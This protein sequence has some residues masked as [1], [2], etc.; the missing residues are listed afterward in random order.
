VRVSASLQAD[1]AR[2]ATSTAAWRK[3]NMLLSFDLHEGEPAGPA[4]VS[5]FDGQAVSERPLALRT[6]LATGVP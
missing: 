5:P 6:G 4:G 2:A 1:K 3:R